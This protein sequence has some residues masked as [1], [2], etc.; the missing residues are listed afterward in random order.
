VI[1]RLQ[2]SVKDG[3]SSSNAQRISYQDHRFVTCG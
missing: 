2:S 3:V 1:T